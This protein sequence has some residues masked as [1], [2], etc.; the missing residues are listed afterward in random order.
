[1]YQ[2][3]D[4]GRQAY[5]FFEPNMNARAVERQSIEADLR[6]ALERQE[7]VLHYQPK[8]D[9]TT[10]AISGAEALVRW[11]H[12][13]RGLLSP[14]QFIPIAEDCRLI[15]PIGEWVLGEACRQAQRWAA[16]GLAFG[17]M[18]AN[19][20]AMQFR[21]A[22]F[23]QRIF[24]ILSESGLDPKRLE[25]ELTESV[26]MTGAEST[27]CT[28]QALRGKG[29]QVALDDFGTGYSSLSFLQK[30]PVDC[31]KIDQSFIRQISAVEGAGALVTGIIQMAHALGLRVVAE[32]VETECELQFLKERHS[33]EAQGFYF[34]RPLTPETFTELLEVHSNIVPLFPIARESIKS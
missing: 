13:T 21:N 18:A 22:D 19:V 3:K 31:L 12:P 14:A 10:R 28:L 1:M 15:V 33:D 34:S 4:M 6:R 7:L 11:Q 8:I 9:L 25:L 2:A 29:V 17:T 20:S 30:F 16:A 24:D 5:R 26:L 23:A 32:G 27:A